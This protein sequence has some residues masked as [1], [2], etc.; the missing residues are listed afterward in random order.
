MTKNR[1][2]TLVLAVAALLTGGVAVAS[3]DDH[4]GA[5]RPGTDVEQVSA[6][7]P[8]VAETM[9]ALAGS[10][11]SADAM[12]ED[13]ANR[14][15]GRP[16][17]GMNP[18]LSRLAV[19]NASNSLYLVPADGHVCAALTVGDGA[20]YSCRR[21]STIADG[22]SGAATVLL[23]TGDIGV[24][25]MVP[26]SVDSVTLQTGVSNTAQVD[27]SENAY[28]TVVDAGTPL[29]SVGYAGPSGHVEFPI[30]DPALPGESVIRD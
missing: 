18:D 22:S 10:R 14:L 25:G 6:I 26:D 27:V 23:E 29:G 15:D 13:I 9:S 3:A 19:G 21:I 16:L 17:F 7:D 30:H 2:I 5:T 1:R 8:A 12:P 28:Y 4:G 20:N 24:Y 11:R